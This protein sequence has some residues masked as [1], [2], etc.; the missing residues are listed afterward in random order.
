MHTLN[1]E[2]EVCT[3]ETVLMVG[4]GQCRNQKIFSLK[5]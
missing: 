5:M 4:K 3:E 1:E 2:T